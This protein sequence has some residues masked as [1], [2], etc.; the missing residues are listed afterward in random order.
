[1]CLYREMER[2]AQRLT[3]S[4]GYEGLGTVEY[5]FNP[6][7]DSFYFLELNPRLQVE[8]PVTEAVTG[9]NL[10]ALQLQ[11]GMG[12]PLHRVPSIRT[13]FGRHPEGTDPIDFL[14]EDYVPLNLHVIAVSLFLLLSEHIIP[15][16][17]LFLF[18]FV[19]WC[20]MST[21]LTSDQH[22]SF[23]CLSTYCLNGV[24][25]VL[26]SNISTVSFVPPAHLCCLLP[27]LSCQGCFFVLRCLVYFPHAGRCSAAVSSLSSPSL[28]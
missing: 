16:P 24:P 22:I 19:C 9:Q 18:L 23:C 1:M 12:I 2:A 25:L 21:T 3:Q 7:T 5:L 15:L 4:L 10:P 8:H 17:P 20:T 14:K 11:I 6:M 28:V 27:L 13:F 26:S